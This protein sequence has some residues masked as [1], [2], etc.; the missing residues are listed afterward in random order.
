MNL[1]LF[2]PPGAGKGTQSKKLEE[3]YRI[4]QI[5]TGDMLRAARAQKTPLGMEAEKY[6]VAG[7]LVPDTVMIGLIDLRLKAEDCESGFILDGFPRTIPQAQSLRETLER[8]RLR[9]NRVVNIEVDEEE[10]VRR[11]TGRRQCAKCNQG[12]H[13]V[14]APPKSEG[15]CDRCGGQLFQ[16]DDD[17]E[18]TIRARLKVYREQTQPLIDYYRN[19]G[20][21]ETVKGCAPVEDVFNAIVKILEKNDRYQVTGGN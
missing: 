11:L 2:G 18:K 16:R 21:L 10:L 8:R 17:K 1:I 15:V 6:T 12:Y 4:P 13:L 5:S 14:F 19:E 7:K 9:L 20:F 3:F